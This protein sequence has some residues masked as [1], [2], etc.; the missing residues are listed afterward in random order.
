M[1]TN[2]KYVTVNGVVYTYEEYLE[3]LKNRD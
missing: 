1:K 3:M 2:R